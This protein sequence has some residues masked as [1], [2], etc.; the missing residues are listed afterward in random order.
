MK[1][2]AAK[3]MQKKPFA[4]QKIVPAFFLLIP[5]LR[6]RIRIRD[7]WE[8]SKDTRSPN[9][10]K[11]FKIG[12]KMAGPE[13]FLVSPSY[14]MMLLSPLLPI[15]SNHSLLFSLCRMYCTMP[16]QNKKRVKNEI[17]VM[18]SLILGSENNMF[19]ISRSYTL[20]VTIFFITKIP[21]AI[22]MTAPPTMIL[23]M[24]SENKMPKYI[25]FERFR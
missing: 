24:G 21:M 9:S 13:V 10:L 15:F 16:K 14:W 4:P 5:A 11:K 25:G 3:N 18:I 7:S 22:I 23:P 2:S 8:G 19:K 6:N 17:E 12:V 1:N 20:M